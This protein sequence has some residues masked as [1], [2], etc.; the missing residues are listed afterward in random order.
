M[1]K[2][3]GRRSYV[4]DNRGRFA[5]T[6]GGSGSK[7]PAKGRSASTGRPQPRTFR[8]RQQASL[9]RRP[10]QGG[11]LGKA[12]RE[13]KAKL[14]ASKAKLKTNATPQQRAAVTR[15]AIRAEGASPVTRMRRAAAA[16]VLRGVKMTRAQGRRVKPGQAAQ[17][18]QVTPVKP[19][20]QANPLARMAT[21]GRKRVRLTGRLI[22]MNARSPV[23]FQPPPKKQDN[24]FGTKDQTK[25]RNLQIALDWLK[26]KGY[27]DA[28][29]MK[30]GAVNGMQTTAMVI[31]KGGYYKTL[32]GK[33]VVNR[34]EK[35][36]L[37]LNAAANYW[38]N[39]GKHRREAR[40]SGWSSTSSPVGTLLHEIAH[41]KDSK[42]E[43]N[44]RIYGSNPYMLPMR[45]GQRPTG[46]A[47]IWRRVS[48]YAS[49]TQAEFIAETSAGLQSGRKYDREVMRTYRQAMGLSA[50]PPARMR[51]RLPRRRK[52]KA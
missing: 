51:S 19:Q 4:R 25:N 17:A 30:K 38:R 42:V 12:T 10:G 6:P 15:A 44:A 26:S 29:L 28:V 32:D 47:G 11:Y 35:P 20:R 9:D 14:R 2:G 16:G 52:P 27:G 48:Q 36:V 49:R 8:Q 39:P 46:L 40:R 13:A 33:Y 45:G 18:P 22:N 7:K 37:A 1:V 3:G 31:P 50:S 23:Q 34:N 5:S 24:P 21:I 41:M 43:Q